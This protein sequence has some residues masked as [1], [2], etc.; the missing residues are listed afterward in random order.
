MILCVGISTHTGSNSRLELFSLGILSSRFTV[1]MFGWLNAT[2]NLKVYLMTLKHS[3]AVIYERHMIL[4]KP[5]SLEKLR[6]TKSRVVVEARIITRSSQYM[7]Y[8]QPRWRLLQ[9]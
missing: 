7:F 1:K 3:V 4:V 5:E 8:V 6:K 9:N 2:A